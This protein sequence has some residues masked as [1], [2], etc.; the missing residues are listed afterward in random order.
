MEKRAEPRCAEHSSNK[1]S[2]HQTDTPL[3]LGLRQLSLKDQ[4]LKEEL[5]LKAGKMTG[6]KD[7]WIGKKAPRINRKEAQKAEYPK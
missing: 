4:F 3:R 6:H 5:N 7:C 2:T 1:T